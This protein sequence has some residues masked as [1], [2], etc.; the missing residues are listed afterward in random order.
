MHRFP[1]AA[2]VCSAGLLAA[3]PVALKPDTA[4]HLNGGL[5]AG[6]FVTP[7]ARQDWPRWMQ[8]LCGGKAA[9]GAKDFEG[10]DLRKVPDLYLPKA[11]DLLRTHRIYSFRLLGQVAPVLHAAPSQAWQKAK[12]PYMVACVDALGLPVEDAALCSRVITQLIQEGE[13]SAVKDAL[14]RRPAKDR[15]IQASLLRRV[16]LATGTA[17]PSWEGALDRQLPPAERLQHLA[18]LR[19]PGDAA[20]LV[21]SF[22]GTA[23][24]AHAAWI[25]VQKDWL[26]IQHEAVDEALKAPTVPLEEGFW[27][28]TKPVDRRADLRGMRMRDALGSGQ[29]KTA[30]AEARAI[31]S[32]QP[33]SIH[34]GAAAALL[35][36]G[37][38]TLRVPGDITVLS[39]PHVKARLEPVSTRWPEELKPLAERG[40]FDLILLKADPD[41]Q[42]ERF[43]QAAHACGQIDLVGRYFSGTRSYAPERMAAMFPTFLVPLLEGF[44]KEEGVGHL[45][46]PAFVLAM[47]KNESLFQPCA[48]SPAKAYGLLQLLK[49]TFR[50]MMGKR[51]DIL[52]PE[53][54]IRG[55]LRYYL[56]VGRRASLAGLPQNV[57][58]AY[59]CAGYHAGEG[60]AKRWKNT[61]EDRLQNKTD[62]A[63]TI[64]RL[65]AIPITST[66]QY[67]AHVLGDA[68][69]YRA[70]L[71]K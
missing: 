5:I 37:E 52:D 46:D 21:R 2:L 63:S 10:A 45:V 57:R 61:I 30:E 22:K 67:I 8:V 26:G 68:E 17:K 48:F 15:A 51:A 32:E 31:L 55:G 24:H 35:G 59:I 39:A 70:L 54:N 20:A 60:R 11:V 9:A 36:Q 50:A 13:G 69:I 71:K 25:A 53:T 33:A 23:L 34:A 44:I 29:R 4:W 16:A 65:E 6:G 41:A 58:Q 12:T 66:R 38:P 49:P 40:R 3:A 18:K 56:T 64:L 42:P 47:M 7:S 14:Q 62:A 1:L 43:L 28:D 27:V 19:Q